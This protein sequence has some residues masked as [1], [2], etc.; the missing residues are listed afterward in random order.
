MYAIGNPNEGN[1]ENSPDTIGVAAQVVVDG[2]TYTLA[3]ASKSGYNSES[4]LT[5]N[6][7]LLVHI[8]TPNATATF[9]F[10]VIHSGST[11]TAY[12]RSP[13]VRYICIKH[14]S[15]STF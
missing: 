6:T 4:T 14:I 11:G 1:E 7:S 13:Q 8:P 15:R 3:S 10:K 2:T 12:F 9:G 5:G